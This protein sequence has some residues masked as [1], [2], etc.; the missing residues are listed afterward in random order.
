MCQIIQ[1]LAIGG[2]IHRFPCVQVKY[3]R[4]NIVQFNA[5]LLYPIFQRGIVAAVTNGFNVAVAVITLNV[6]WLFVQQRCGCCAIIIV[7]S[8][9]IFYFFI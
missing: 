7:L 8:K 4:N 1:Q 2:N 9:Q 5:K 3:Y 6:F